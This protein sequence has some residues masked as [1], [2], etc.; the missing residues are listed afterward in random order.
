MKKKYITPEIKVI[1]ICN[2]GLMQTTS[3]LSELPD[4]VDIPV[5]EEPEEDG[6]GD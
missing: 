4:E 5:S 6:Y 1:A 2:H 3:R